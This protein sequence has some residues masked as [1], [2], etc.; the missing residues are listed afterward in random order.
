MIFRILLSCFIF[1]SI[2]ISKGQSAELGLKIGD[3]VPSVSLTNMLNYKA[4]KVS[5]DEFKG[6]IV[7]L[8]F[9]NKY[10]SACI[11]AFPKM[12]QLQEKFGDKIQVLLVTVNSKEELS[13]LFQHSPNVINNKLPMVLE[14][15]IL[16]KMFPH[17]AEPYLV[18]LNEEGKVVAT[19]GGE[20]ATADNIQAVLDGNSTTLAMRRDQVTFNREMPLL[21]EGEGRQWRHLQYYS[22]IMNWVDGN[23]G[24]SAATVIDPITHKRRPGRCFYN[25]PI[26]GLYQLAFNIENINAPI[27]IETENAKSYFKPYNDP[28]KQL[29]WNRNNLYNYEL[30]VPPER[31][32][33]IGIFMRQDL[34]RFFGLKG[35]MEKRSVNA[36]VLF[37]LNKR[38][39]LKTKGGESISEKTKDGWIFKNVSVKNVMYN[40]SRNYF[41][42]GMFQS[43]IDSTGYNDMID[44]TLQADA[45]LSDLTAL[46]KGLSKYGLAV[47]EEEMK[48]ECLVIKK[49]ESTLSMR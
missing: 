6:K 40:L 39:M 26:I 14:D 18:W 29:E 33:E 3:K 34:E 11:R 43:F 37:R 15:T 32:D 4:N 46:N 48:L 30:V 31:E 8:D 27:I 47:K 28:R 10:C 25:V 41:D 1:S 35:V 19:T 44:L 42:T 22:M 5:L 21:M 7:I 17:T 12:T 9:W 23:P 49:S 20:E 38:D 24:T 13:Y 2:M 16:S 45:D 36:L